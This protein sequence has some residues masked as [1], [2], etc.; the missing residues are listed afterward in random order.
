MNEG[1]EL[2][3]DDGVDPEHND[4]EGKPCPTRSSDFI[5]ILTAPRFAQIRT[6]RMVGH[7]GMRLRLNAEGCDAFGSLVHLR[8]VALPSLGSPAAGWPRLAK[9]LRGVEEAWI[10]HFGDA[11]LAVAEHMTALARLR[12]DLGMCDSCVTDTDRFCN[13]DICGLKP[14]SRVR[15]LFLS[16]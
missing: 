5:P 14:F 6:L 7:A 9:G 3:F 13:F 11:F 4:A 2:V 15:H 8:R 10:R 16:R 12:F 1:T